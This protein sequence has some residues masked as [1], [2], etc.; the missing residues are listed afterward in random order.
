MD[1]GYL[2]LIPPLVA[3]GLAFITRK[4]VLSLIV[5]IVSG[6]F[7]ATKWQIIA[8]IKKTITIIWQSTEAGNF[9]NFALF[10]DSWNL[11][12]LLTDS[13]GEFLTSHYRHDDVGYD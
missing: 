1:Y 11:F 12:I 4:V 3:I 8:T 10:M 5:G 6:A 13:A 7:I 2:S 9:K